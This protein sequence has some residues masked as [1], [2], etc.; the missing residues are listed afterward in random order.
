[1][2]FVFLRRDRGVG[3]LLFEQFLSLVFD[4]TRGRR[5][6]TFTLTKPSEAKASYQGITLRSRQNLP[7]SFCGASAASQTMPEAPSAT[8][9]VAFAPPISVRTHPGQT[10]LMAKFGN[11]AASCTVTPFRAVFEMQ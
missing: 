11:A 5:S 9:R 10:E 6:K 2:P 7:V 1:M 4:R 3:A 8:E